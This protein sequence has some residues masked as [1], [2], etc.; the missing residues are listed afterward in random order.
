[1][2]GSRIAKKRSTLG[3]PGQ[4]AKSSTSVNQLN[5]EGRDKSFQSLNYLKNSKQ[6][7]QND[8]S[9]NRANVNDFY[10]N[11][12]YHSWNCGTMNIRSG[13]EKLEGAKIYSVTKEVAKANLDFFCLQEV[14]HRS[15]GRNIIELNSGEKYEFIWCGQKKNVGIR[16]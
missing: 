9:Y 15:T 4:A 1:M 11:K 16:G 3:P 8:Q 12:A 2:E 7:C 14:R 13:K 10:Y 6:G 5:D